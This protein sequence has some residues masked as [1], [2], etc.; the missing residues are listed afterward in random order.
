MPDP[1]LA[2]RDF[3]RAAGALALT[4]AA[5]AGL[6]RP[7]SAGRTPWPGYEDALVLDFLAS[8]G[9]FNTTLDRR[10]DD[11]MV[12]NAVAS[13]ITAVN[14]TVSGGDLEGTM[15]RMAPWSA[16]LARH[17]QALVQVR[18]VSDLGAA[19]ET[20][21]LGLIF[22]FQDSTPLEGDLDRIDLFHDLGVRVI[23][24]TYNGRN[25]AGDGC[26]EPGNAG[27]SRW[28]HALVER[29]EEKGL[30]VDLAHCGQR[31]TADGIA[32]A[33]GPVAISHSG[34]KAIHDNP[35]SKRDEE[36][37]AMADKGGV[38]G[39]YL[40]PFLAPGRPATADDVMAHVEHALDVCGE[41]HVGIGSDLSITPIEKDDAEYW[42]AHREFVARRKASG[43]AAPGEDEEI[44]FYVEDL[45]T[46][47]RLERIADHMAA[48]GHAARVIEKV[49]GGNFAR[50]IEEV[51]RA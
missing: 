31:T 48:R 22:G 13:G 4:P 24:L 19:K 43:S 37:R 38:V 6:G 33:R 44:L 47:R 50:L 12:A 16:A 46:P 3:L 39:I 2:R 49:V 29:M 41:D 40:M 35:R 15:G 21:R 51:W 45:N 30:V 28:G 32:A 25:L 36:L 27:L 8:P 18:T 10:L 34:C 20:G 42:R 5:L 11:A 23:Q 17:P 9:L 14:L 7:R 26:L 1:L